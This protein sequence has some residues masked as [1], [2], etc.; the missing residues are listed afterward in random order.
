MALGETTSSAF[1]TLREEAIKQRD[2]KKLEEFVSAIG[3]LLHL[4]ER[5]LASADEGVERV[6]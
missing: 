4:L 5:C 6:Q 1:R 3:D 2:I